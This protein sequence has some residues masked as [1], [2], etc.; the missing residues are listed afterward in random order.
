M[1]AA[2]TAA[3]VRATAMERALVWMDWPAKQNGVEGP[4]VHT[5]VAAAVEGA[6]ERSADETTVEA[7]PGGQVCWAGRASMAAFAHGGCRKTVKKNEDNR[8]VS[9]RALRAANHP[10]QASRSAHVFEQRRRLT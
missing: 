9:R 8:G 7:G 1:W 6:V 3:V 4:G 2:T 10:Q 5:A